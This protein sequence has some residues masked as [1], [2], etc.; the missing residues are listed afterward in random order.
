M[1]GASAQIG[2]PYRRAEVTAEPARDRGYIREV[3]PPAHCPDRLLEELVRELPGLTVIHK[4]RDVL[5]RAIDLALRVLTLGG[6]R[7]YSSRYTTVIGRRI[8]LP[9]GWEARSPEERY[10][11]LRHEAVHLRQF[12]RHG[13][14]PMA[15]AYLFFPLPMGLS[16]ARARIEWEAYAETFRATA[17]VHGLEAAR[18]P[19]LRDYVIAQF[20]GPAYGYMLPSR[21]VVGGWIDAVLGELL[22]N[23]TP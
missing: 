18:S 5:S 23:E 14:L 13:L 7:E 9:R 19:A 20:V 8:Y 12:A 1:A 3:T 10:V 4:E 17:E 16:W 2:S 11:T 22:A 15:L 21:R 6:Q